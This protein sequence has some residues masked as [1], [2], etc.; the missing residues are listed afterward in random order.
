MRG[1]K[2]LSSIGFVLFA[3]GCGGYDDL[4]I[5][6][7]NSPEARR[8]EILKALDR[9][10]YDFVIQ[11][12]APDPT[13]GG[14]FTLEEGRF[15]LAAAYVGKA[16]FDANDVL[17]ELVNSAGT[18]SNS[19]QLFIE[20][21]ASNV[22][23][24]NI[25]YLSR[26]SAL[27]DA[28][29][30]NVCEQTA[31]TESLKRDACFYKAIIDAA[32]AAVTVANIV[33]DVDSWLNPQGCGEDANGNSV[34]DEADASA[35]AIEYAV[36]KG[37]DPNIAPPYSCNTSAG[38]VSV[39]SATNLTFTDSQNNSYS[40]ELLSISVGGGSECNTQTYYRLID[41]SSGALAVTEG[42]CDTSFNP[43]SQV[44]P[45]AGCY[46]C[47]VV[48]NG[49]VLDLVETVVNTIESAQQIITNLVQGTDA[50]QAVNNFIQEV[51]GNDGVCT[52]EDL[53]GYL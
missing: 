53:A 28:V 3:A 51:C 38:T 35:C 44:D 49:N 29:A 40:F 16:G 8:Y 30:D 6:S 15:N 20:A 42:Y 47:P 50:E 9:G 25:P 52:Q 7:R 34:G 22:S 46:P 41:S 14:A 17:R 27:Y 13:Y 39:D 4:G 45:N 37:N 10:D 31:P 2:I 5:S 19:F 21:I 43:C 48:D 36:A 32:T 33:G 11:A 18:T 24:G 12:L 23:A 26:A 1:V